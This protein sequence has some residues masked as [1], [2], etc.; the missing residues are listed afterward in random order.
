MRNR[1]AHLPIPDARTVIA[2]GVLAMAIAAL[3]VHASL[4]VRGGSGRRVDSQARAAGPA[5][6]AAAYGYPLRCLA[7]TI[8][9][10]DPRYARADFDRAVRCGRYDG[11]ATAIFHR[12]DGAWVRALDSSSYSCP[13]P[14]LPSAVQADLAICP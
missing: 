9:P 3:V 4:T 13:V 2:I 14:S 8:A 7:V 6:V 1:I 11:Y 5:G 10:H 12:V